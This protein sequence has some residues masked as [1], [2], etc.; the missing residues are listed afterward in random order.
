MQK[1]TVY[2][3]LTLALL[4][5]AAPQKDT[6]VKLETQAGEI[7]L[8]LYDS[9]PI[10]RDNFIKLV[11]EGFYDSLLFHRVIPGFMIQGGDPNSKNAAPGALVGGGGPGYELD[12]EIKA[13]HVRGALAAA[14][15]GNAVNPRKRSSGS[16]FFIVQG[17]PQ[18]DETLNQWEGRLGF[19]F[20]PEW[21]R[22]YIEKG[23]TPQLEG[24]YT[25]FGEVVKGMEVVDKIAAFPRD[26]NDRPLDDIRIL[27]AR[28]QR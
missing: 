24:Q 15:L 9:T 13:P 14:R 22:Q 28:I 1:K 19:K 18:T 17:E 12:P 2:L 25:V 10:H 21:R 16:Q 4:S 5:C 7:V 6:L 3:L 23:G 8:K 26:E 27:K 20:S 11:E